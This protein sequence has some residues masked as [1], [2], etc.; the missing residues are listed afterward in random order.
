MSIKIRVHILSLKIAS[1]EPISSE[2]LVELIE[3]FE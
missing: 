2:E 1:E 3:E